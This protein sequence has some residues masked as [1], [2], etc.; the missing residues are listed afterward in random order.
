M[1]EFCYECYKKLHKSAGNKSDYV[2][3]WGYDLCEGCGEIKHVVTGRRPKYFAFYG[4]S[5]LLLPFLIVGFVF[6][7]LIKL[8]K[9]IHLKIK[10]NKK[11][12]NSS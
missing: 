8:I 11:R 3:S 4:S 12:K 9:H 1:A 2:I 7:C 6:Y 10:N 5:F